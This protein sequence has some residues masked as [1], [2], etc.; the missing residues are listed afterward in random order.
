MASEDLGETLICG[1][2]LPRPRVPVA[3]EDA[4][5]GPITAA[6][7][8]RLGKEEAGLIA[9][10]LLR[11]EQGLGGRWPAAGGQG[12]ALQEEIALISLLERRHLAAEQPIS[13]NS[14]STVVVTVSMGAYEAAPPR[15]WLTKIFPP[16]MDIFSVSL[17]ST[18]WPFTTS[19]S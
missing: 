15:T 1:N 12:N 16:L 3:I 19:S 2:A 13:A 4:V 7:A 6:P 5:Y 9:I 8:H 11:A 18:N 10:A 14:S 17:S